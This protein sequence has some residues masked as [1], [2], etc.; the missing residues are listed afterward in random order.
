LANGL[1]I[2]TPDLD[3]G[4][5]WEHPEFVRPLT[6]VNRGKAEAVVVN[7]AGGCECTS[8]EPKQFT[9]PPGQSK[10]VNATIDLTHRFPHQ[11][12]MDRR[13]LAVTV[14]PVLASRGVSAE[15]WKVTGV[16]KSRVSLE[17][18]GLEFADLCSSGGPPVT[19]KMRATA[20]VPL[21]GLEAIVPSGA[22]KVEVL[23]VVGRP[24][25]FDILV[26]PNPDRPQGEFKFDVAVNA[27]NEAG[28]KS[29]C[30]SFYAK[31]EMVS[32]VRV[33][34][35]TILLGEHP[36]GEK[37]AI[38]VTLQF[39]SSKWSLVRVETASKSLAVSPANP[40]SQ[41]SAI[42]FVQSI[43]EVSDCTGSIR[44]VCRN[45]SGE[46]EVVASRITYF[47]QDK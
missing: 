28:V 34:P 19:R 43:S 30:A 31:G 6:I 47:G 5:V 2:Q 3:I 29:R 15:S 20:H 23:S 24:N 13:E 9:I 22:G 12:G 11:F 38:T 46:L 32:P 7:M 36:V 35:S 1:E 40:T 27:I 14:T 42:S 39:P 37:V 44:F 10:P 21:K 16:I 33:V 41:Q 18:R 8:I 26:T 17:S 25:R 4:E 45:P